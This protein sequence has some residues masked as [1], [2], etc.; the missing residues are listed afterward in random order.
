M[1]PWER[2]PGQP[3]TCTCT[4]MVV[5]TIE[6]TLACPYGWRY[7]PGTGWVHVLPARRPR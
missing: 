4:R 5:A 3:E 1:K 6:E 7:A 2:W